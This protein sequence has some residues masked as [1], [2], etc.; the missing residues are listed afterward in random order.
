M[1][2][3]HCASIAPVIRRKTDLASLPLAGIPFAV[4]DLMTVAGVRTTFG[5]KAFE[6]NIPEQSDLLIERIEAAG[7][8]VYCKTNTPEFGAGANTFNE[9]FGYTRNPWDAR[10]SAAGSSGGSAVAL[11]TGMAWLA[12]GSD[13]GGSLRNPASF[14][15]VVGFRPSQGLVP[16]DPGELAFN[17]SSMD[18]PMARNVVDVAMFLD[19]MAGHDPRDPMS[20]RS[21]SRVLR[22]RGAESARTSA[23]CIFKGSRRDTCR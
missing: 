6:N 4:K 1:Q 13:L 2:H 19:V 17:R 11:A 21:A 22:K 9:V 3:R 8:L 16:A 20:L 5:S 14:C 23:H 12:T 18:G 10:L 7:G 15:S